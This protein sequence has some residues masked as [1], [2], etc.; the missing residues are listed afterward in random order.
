MSGHSTAPIGYDLVVV[1]TLH[2]DG[3]VSKRVD[4][5]RMMHLYFQIVRI[6]AVYD[7]L[8]ISLLEE[9]R[10]ISPK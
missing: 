8:Y 1:M 5:V 9:I 3:S 2:I 4:V 7:F 10:V 6:K